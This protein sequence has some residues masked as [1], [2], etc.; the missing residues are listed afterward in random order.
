MKNPENTYIAYPEN[1][2]AFLRSNDFQFKKKY[3]QNF[4]IDLR[5]VDK[6]VTATGLTEHDVCVEIGPGIGSLTQGLC[7]AAGRVIAVEIDKRLIP[8]LQHNLAAYSNV[9]IV[10]AD[11]LEADLPALLHGCG[12]DGLLQKGGRLCFVGNLP[13][14][15]TTPILTRIFDSGLPIASLT[16]M[17][18]EEVAHRIQSGPGTKEYGPLSL[19]ARYYSKTDIVAYVP[20]NCFIPRPGVGSAVMRF[21]FLPEP[22]VSVSDRGR[23]F[24]LIEAAFGQRRKTLPN[25]L[26]SSEKLHLSKE[27][28]IRLTQ[29][30]GFDVQVRGEALTLEE[31]ARLAE[32]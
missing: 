28:A 27:E 19:M 11:F 10:E 20:Q 16:A 4:L 6:I 12:A 32:A 26:S 14:Y 7:E 3:G 5:V 15:I 30:A 21:D 8:V 17:M 9:S 1:T 31:F 29:E 13:Y 23:L 18:Q 2:V 24:D 25:A 22:A